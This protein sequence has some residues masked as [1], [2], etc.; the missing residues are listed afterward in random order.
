[1]K[2]HANKLAVAIA[3]CSLSLS[4]LTQ[5]QKLEEVVVTAAKVEASIQDTPIA[6]TAFSQEALDSQLINDSSAMQFSVPNLTQ[7]KGNFAG[8]DIRIRGIGSGAVGT[9]GDSGV[10]IHVNGIY[11]VATRIFETQFLDMERVEVLRGPQGTLYGRNTTGGVINLITAKADPTEFS[12]SLDATV[13]NYGANQGRFHI[14]APLSDT[15]AFRAAGMMLNRDGF[16]ENLFT[17]NDVDDRSL[18]S[19]RL[20]FTWDAGENTQVNFM[21]SLFEEDDSRMRSQKQACNTDPS[22]TLGCLPGSPTYG[23]A[24]GGGIG[25]ALMASISGI[26]DGSQLFLGLAGQLGLNPGNAALLANT[27]MFGDGSAVFSA[28]FLS[29]NNPDDRRKVNMDYEPTYFAE[30]EMFQL[31]LTHDEG[32]LTYSWSTGY[33]ENVIRSTE[34]YEKGVA[35]GSWQPGLDALVDLGNATA[36]SLAQYAAYQGAAASFG[37]PSIP[38]S[39]LPFLVD[40]AGPGT[41]IWAGNSALLGDLGSG[42]PVLMPDGTLVR[43]SKQFGADQSMGM[44]EGWSHEFRVQSNF[45]GDLNF[46]LGAMNLDYQ[47][48]GHYVVRN[49]GIG[50]PGQILP[51]NQAVFPAP[52]NLTDPSNEVSPHMWGYENDTRLYELDAQ[53]LFGELYYDVNQDLRL[54]FGARY[55]EEEKKSKQRTIYV[56][57]ADL[58]PLD[59]ENNAY[60]FPKYDQEEFTWKLNA[61]YNMSNDTMVYGTVSSSF[62]SGGVNPISVDDDLADPAAGGDP[63]NLG[64]KPEFVDAFEIGMK[65]TFMDGAAQFNGAFFF[66]DYK[67]MQQSKIVSVTSLNQNSDAEITGFEGE[68]RMA[69]SDNLEFTANVGWVDAEIGEYDTVDT[70]NPN[71]Q[72][73]TVGVTSING[74]NFIVPYVDASGNLV[75]VD[76]SRCDQPAPFPCAGYRQ[77]L[78]GNQIALTPEFNYNL[79]LIYRSEMGGMP[80]FMQTNYYWQDKM[81][82]TNFNTP[83]TEIED[84]SMWNASARVMGNGWYAEAWV[85]NILDDDNITG[86]YLTSSVSSLFTN[87]FILEPRTYGLTVGMRF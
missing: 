45:D 43:T 79:G 74:V 19:G 55:S 24:N 75:P 70:A 33:T 68:L 28:P 35:N 23:V 60:G 1:M 12:A 63:A 4:G 57:F 37:L 11:Q 27:A 50:L 39:L 34:D 29:D 13:G 59:P 48:R 2:S 65:T 85:R 32:D 67:D 8:G 31:Q 66:Y 78:A 52:S 36:L 69:L 41:A 15:L 61:T 16:T 81:Y 22:G 42:I 47:S 6:V 25:D 5:A 84:W 76:Y 82:T 53:A 87:Q 73:N 46:L 62:K 3:A 83:G 54:T 86:G 51:I 56:T 40:F 72:G 44:D 30:E 7:T 9:F 17:G 38:D 14:N 26:S 10:G 49:A 77:S 20:S 80:L 71:A 18:W 58:P 21:Y 64:F